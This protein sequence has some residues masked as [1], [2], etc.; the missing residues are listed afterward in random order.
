MTFSLPSPPPWS[1]LGIVSLGSCLVLLAVKLSARSLGVWLEQRRWVSFLGHRVGRQHESGA[2][3]AAVLV[4]LSSCLARMSTSRA[5]FGM[6]SALFVGGHAAL[7]LLIRD[8]ETGGWLQGER[9]LSL[10]HWSASFAHLLAA[11]SL[12]LSVLAYRQR[13]REVEVAR[14]VL[15]RCME[16]PLKARPPGELVALS[17]ELD[18]PVVLNAALFSILGLAVGLESH[19]SRLGSYAGFEFSP[20]ACREEL[21]QLEVDVSS[22]EVAL[23][24]LSSAQTPRLD[25]RVAAERRRVRRK[26]SWLTFRPARVDLPSAPPRGNAAPPLPRE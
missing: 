18:S 9:L 10:P 15:L 2:S 23:V 22:L 25:L 24:E 1:P 8:E 6:G 16:K 26:V 4:L 20:E 17:F 5:R 12:Y 11:G 21:S 14:R 19:W 3:L 7:L 13:L